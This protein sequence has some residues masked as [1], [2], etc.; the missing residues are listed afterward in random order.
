MSDAE[1]EQTYRD[2][3]RSYYT[4]EHI[5]TVARRHGAIPRPQP[6]RAGAVHDRRYSM[7]IEPVGVFHYKLIYAR[8]VWQ[9]WRI[10]Q[11]V[12][13]DPKRHEYMNLALSPVVEDAQQAARRGFGVLPGGWKTLDIGASN[14]SGCRMFSPTSRPMKELAS[15]A[16]PITHALDRRSPAGA[17]A[18]VPPR[19]EGLVR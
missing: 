3:W 1:Y 12:L 13:H 11:K 7:P 18:I 14:V 16:V 17:E 19:I 2:A 15:I 6:G 4:S 8:L 5:E 9:G 10:G